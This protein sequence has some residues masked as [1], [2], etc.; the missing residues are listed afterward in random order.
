MFRR[1]GSR[2]TVVH[3][4][5]QILPH[6]DAD[7]AEALQQSLEGEGIRFLLGA[8]TTRVE[9]EQGGVALSVAV[10]G[11]TETVHGSHLLVATGR[12]PNTDDLGLQE[13]GVQ[14]DQRGFIRVN[15]RLET[16]VP[17]SGP[18]G[19]SRAARRSHISP[20]MTTRSCTPT[21]LMANLLPPTTA[22]SPTPSS[23]TP[24]WVVSV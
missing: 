13:A 1:F 14:T 16:N 20:T 5:K 15:N 22:Q 24:N 3:R 19:M 4:E 11:T 23:P 8:T 21:S 18:W 2:V 17:A 12:K 6:E 7:A 10:E 9:T